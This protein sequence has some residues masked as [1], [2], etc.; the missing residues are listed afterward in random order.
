METKI[1]TVLV[2]PGEA[3]EMLKANIRNR[4]LRQDHVIRLANEMKSGGWVFNGEPIQFSDG[5]V[6]LNGQHRLA[7]IVKSQTSQKVVI[8][9]GISGEAFKTYDIGKKRSNGDIFHIGGV[10]DPLNTAAVVKAYTAN[11]IG[12]GL[13]ADGNS[14]N[15]NIEPHE[16]LEIF[17]NNNEIFTEVINNARILY[18][19]MRLMT[20]SEV[21]GYMAFLIIDKKHPSGKVYSFFHQLFF[22]EDVE[23]T[24]INILREK[25]INSRLTNFKM[26]YRYKRALVIKCWNAYCKGKEL[27]SLTFNED[28]EIYPEFI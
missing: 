2:T 27:K 21:G 17:N 18:K 15:V 19:K 9:R 22:A 25:I 3:L 1:E 24:V 20:L 14:T 7:A 6:L 28:K 4:P 13:G 5:G 12:L 26:T 11:N 16:Y 23:N 8:I 10:K